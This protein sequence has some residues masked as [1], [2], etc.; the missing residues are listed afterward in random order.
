MTTTITKNCQLKQ[1]NATGELVGYASV[2]GNVDSD[3]EIID[4]GAFRTSLSSNRGIVPILWQHDRTQPVGWATSAEEDSYGLKV[5]GRLMMDCEA[6]RRA[7]SYLKTASTAGGQ[8]GLSIGFT[9]PSGG[10][11][12]KDGVRHFQ[13][14]ELREWSVVTFAA[15]PLAVVT[16]VKSGRTISAATNDTLSSIL[17]TLETADQHHSAIMSAH[18]EALQKLKALVDG[19]GSNDTNLANPVGGGKG[20][21]PL[22]REEA[23]RLIA[24][25]EEF[26]RS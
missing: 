15:N 17:A 18:G 20:Y 19:Y 22:A 3:G 25:V 9:V 1:I 21:D 26:L 2:F 16:A 10:S 7:H 6:G 8:A 12:F 4:R 23:M 5:A 24:E 11:Y 13:A 14:C